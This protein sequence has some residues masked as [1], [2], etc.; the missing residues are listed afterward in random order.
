MLDFTLKMHFIYLFLK[1]KEFM[2]LDK[3]IDV[4]NY[5]K[6]SGKSVNLPELR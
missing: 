5:I 6:L 1:K 3:E 2:R 4:F